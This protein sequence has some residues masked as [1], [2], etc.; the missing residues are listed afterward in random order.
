MVTEIT[1]KLLPTPEL[2]RVIMAGF[3]SVDNAGTAVSDVIGAG[4]IPAGLELMDA[5][6]IQAAEDFVH[7]G[8]PR[9]AAALLLCEVDGTVEEVET[10]IERVNQ[11]F[12][13]AG[14]TSIR[15]ISVAPF[16]TKFE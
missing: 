11:L 9:D 3:D 14:A 15:A 16:A 6:A 12:E 8:Y 5:L 1:V 7:A 13:A 4:I 10:H 2:A